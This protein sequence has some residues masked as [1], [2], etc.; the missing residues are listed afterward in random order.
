MIEAAARACACG[1]RIRLGKCDRCGPKR[2]GRHR[3][4]YGL[5][6]WRKASEQFRM[7][8]PFCNHCGA[9]AELVDHITPHEGN[10]ESFMDRCNWQS[11]CQACHN[12]KT[13]ED[14]RS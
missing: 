5:N 3:E 10:W 13:A 14:N 9:A 7:E 6:L 4:L 1:G 12:K 8:N 11:L 2:Q